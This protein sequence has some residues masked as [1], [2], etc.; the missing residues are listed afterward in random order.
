MTQLLKEY[1]NEMEK[2]VKVVSVEL[3]SSVPLFYAFYLKGT[4]KQLQKNL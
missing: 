2:Q 4:E 1:G 3:N